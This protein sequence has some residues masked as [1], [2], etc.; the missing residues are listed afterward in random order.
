[1]DRDDYDDLGLTQ[2]AT[3]FEIKTAFHTLALQYHPDKTGDGDTS[4]FRCVREAFEK[5]TEATFKREYDHNYANMRMRFDTDSGPKKTRTEAYK[6]EA[7]R[8]AR[9]DERATYEAY[10]EMLRRSPPP[11]QPA[12]RTGQSGTDYYLGRAYQAWAKRDEAYRKN[13][14]SYD[15]A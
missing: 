5:L 14:P 6:T 11:K 7:A 15:Q 10:E 8:K 3:S 1:M 4:A 13:H 2:Q 9:D 12:R